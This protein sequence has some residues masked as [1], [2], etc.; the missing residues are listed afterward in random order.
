MVKRARVS[1]WQARNQRAAWSVEAP[2]KHSKIVEYDERLVLDWTYEHE[3]A[4]QNSEAGNEEDMVAN[5]RMVLR[6]ALE[7][8]AQEVGS[9]ENTVTSPFYVRGIYQVLSIEGRVGWHPEYRKRLGFN[10]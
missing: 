7:D 10:E 8:A 9:I 5:G 6:W 1:E 3:T 4:C 2:S